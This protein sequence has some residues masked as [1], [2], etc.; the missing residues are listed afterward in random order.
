MHE[1][2]SVCVEV[3]DAGGSQR[4]VLGP[5]KVKLQVAVSLYVKAGNKLRSWTR[6]ASVFNH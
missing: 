1:H 4:M 2:L 6:P 3:S 5:L